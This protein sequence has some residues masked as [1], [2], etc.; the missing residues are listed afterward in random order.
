MTTLPF[1]PTFAEAAHSFELLDSCDRSCLALVEADDQVLDI[2][3]DAS[4]ASVISSFSRQFVG[5]SGQVPW[6]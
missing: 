4:E 3:F 5:A 2:E 1:Q 6:N